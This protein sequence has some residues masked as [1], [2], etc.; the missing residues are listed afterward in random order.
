VSRGQFITTLTTCGWIKIT[1]PALKWV[2]KMMPCVMGDM[3]MLPN[4]EVTIING[5]K[6]GVGGW[7]AAKTPAEGP[8]IYRHGNAPRNRF[9]VQ[10]LA[11]TMHHRMYHSSGFSSVTAT[12]SWAAATHTSST[13]STT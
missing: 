10:N 1:D 5:A 11:G 9:E 3:I 4:G 7:E 8:I 2:I 13:S 6:D 12:C